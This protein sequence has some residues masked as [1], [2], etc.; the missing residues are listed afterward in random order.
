EQDVLC[1]FTMPDHGITLAVEIERCNAEGNWEPAGLV[2]KKDYPISVVPVV[3]CEYTGHA[4]NAKIDHWNVPDNATE[5]ET[6]TGW[7]KVDGDCYTP[8]QTTRGRVKFTVNGGTPA[9]STVFTFDCF[10][11]TGEM[12]F[13]FVMPDY[14]VTLTAEIER[15]NEYGEWENAGPKYKKELPITLRIA[16]CEY[17]GHA[18]NAKIDHWNVPDNATE[19]ETVTGWVKVDGDCYT[20]GQTTRGRVKFTVN[21]GT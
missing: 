21:G 3:V 8:G 17:T 6:V 16:E 14:D 5:G 2:Y 18:I 1:S 9:Y 13:S 7:V 12:P 19:G 4:I 15:C 10:G 11:E 20:P